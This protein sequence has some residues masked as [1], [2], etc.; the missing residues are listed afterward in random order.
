MFIEGPLIPAYMEGMQL[1]P[2]KQNTCIH[3]VGGDLKMAEDI[4]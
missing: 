2:N 1:L 3:C 4:A